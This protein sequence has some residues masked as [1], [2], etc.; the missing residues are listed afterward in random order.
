MVV[1]SAL[2]SI[3]SL[4]SVLYFSLVPRL[5][6]SGTIWLR[7]IPRTRSTIRYPGNV[8]LSS[9]LASEDPISA[10]GSM[11]GKQH[12]MCKSECKFMSG[13]YLFL[14]SQARPFPFQCAVTGSDQICGHGR[15]WL[16]RLRT[17][18]PLC[19]LVEVLQWTLALNSHYSQGGQP[20][21]TIYLTSSEHDHISANIH[22]DV[23]K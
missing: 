13:R 19:E 1:F 2:L 17:W 16:A 18:G 7:L 15:V 12:K 5:L 9:W 22:A 20:F 4:G 14:V 23:L 3:T 10:S 11:A 8:C 6:R 21:M